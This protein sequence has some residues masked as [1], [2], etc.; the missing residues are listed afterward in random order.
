MSASLDI[1]RV[2][3]FCDPNNRYGG[4][5]AQ[6]RATSARLA[7]RGHR[8]QLITSDLGVDPR[9]PRDTWQEVDGYRVYYAA[10]RAWH[11][12]P[13]YLPARIGAALEPAL[14]GAD[15][16]CLNVGL[17]VVNARARSAARRH[18][19]P[20]VYNAEGALCPQRLRQRRFAKSVFLRTHERRVLR[21]AAA[22][23]AV[24]P[25]EADDLARQGADPARIHVIPNGVDLAF[26]HSPAARDAFR[27][28]H[29]LPRDAVVVLFLGRL[30]AVKGLDLLLQAAA[31]V[32][33]DHAAVRVVIAGPDDGHEAETRRTAARLGLS[34]RT[35]FTGML[36]GDARRAALSA[37]DVFAL[38]SYSEGMPNAVLEAAAAGL[39]LL[40]TDAC[41]VPE[42]ERYGAGRVVP[43][44]AARLADALRDLTAHA[45]TRMGCGQNARRMVRAQFSLDAVVERLEALYRSVA[46][47]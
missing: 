37:A 42:V 6:A 46:E 13:P 38:T 15:V 10:T 36:E 20:Y 21:S 26:E 5:V 9:I 14:A 18:G 39:P 17:T 22:L 34:D 32:A 47:S 44:D 2:M 3:P 16:L 8:V 12:Q 7:A 23:H 45:A 19:V 27:A 25:I 35:V 11:R 30:H 41:H 4:C 24:T 1:V 28:Q 31:A 43:P 29:G 33:R 40:V